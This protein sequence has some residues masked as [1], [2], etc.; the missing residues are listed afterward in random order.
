MAGRELL[1]RPIRIRSLGASNRVEEF[2]DRA[3]VA[4]YKVPHMPASL[5]I[6]C[7]FGFED[8]GTGVVVWVLKANLYGQRGA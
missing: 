3:I 1:I 4:G 2:L 5:D 7:W 8:M 6:R